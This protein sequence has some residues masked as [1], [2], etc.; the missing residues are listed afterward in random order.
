ML[1]TRRKRTHKLSETM[2]GIVQTLLAHPWLSLVVVYIGGH[3]IRAIYLIYLS[4]LAIFPGSKWAA[5]GE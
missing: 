1:S 4:P 2:Q 5:L 3:V